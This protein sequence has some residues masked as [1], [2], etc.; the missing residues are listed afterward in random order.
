LA[1]AAAAIRRGPAPE[2]EKATPAV[3]GDWGHLPAEPC[4]Y[5]RQVGGVHFLRDDGPEGRDGHQ[6]TRCDKCGR[7]WE[8]GAATA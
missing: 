4:R 8:A 2:A 5:C 6:V 1:E 3:Q 7:S